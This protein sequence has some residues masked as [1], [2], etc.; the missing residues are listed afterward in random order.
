MADRYVEEYNDD[1]D[2]KYQE[3]GYVKIP[4]NLK[5][6]FA[7]MNYISESEL[8]DLQNFLKAFH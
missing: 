1:L 6:F 7:N 3:L 8:R 5:K 2:K 4:G